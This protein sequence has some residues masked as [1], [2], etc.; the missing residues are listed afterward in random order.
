MLIIYD[1]M[2]GNVERFVKRLKNMECI[3]ITKD[4]KVDKPF[5]LVTYT[6]GIGKV[7]KRVQEFLADNHNHLKGVAASGNINWGQ[8][9]AASADTIAEMYGI[10]IVHKFELSGNSTDASK[11]TTRV[12]E[13]E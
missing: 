5:V 13:L 3:K 7:P 10:P 4:L 1:S 12:G 9:F 11:F 6:T 8:V 2:T